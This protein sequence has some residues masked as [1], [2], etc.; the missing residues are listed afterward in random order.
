MKIIE[1]IIRERFSLDKLSQR[2]I[3]DLSIKL[4]K[5]FSDFELNIL[6]VKL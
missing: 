6:E 3:K 5:I 4:K 2:Q 1:L